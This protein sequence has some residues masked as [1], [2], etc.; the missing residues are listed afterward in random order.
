[1][2]HFS[3]EEEKSEHGQECEAGRENGSAQRLIDSAIDDFRQ[4]VAAHQLQ[5]L[6]DTVENDDSVI[7]RISDQRED[8]GDDRQRDL[9]V[10]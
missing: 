3:A 2:Q 7:I 6:T 8:G 9:F 5:V 4:I 1:M 10:G